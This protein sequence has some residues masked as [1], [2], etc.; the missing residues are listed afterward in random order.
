[1]ICAMARTEAE[2][3]GFRLQVRIDFVDT[4]GTGINSIEV[5]NA[6]FDPLP[7]IEQ[8]PR[9]S[10]LLEWSVVIIIDRDERPL[11]IR[12][13]NCGDDVPPTDFPDN[14]P[15]V[16]PDNLPCMERP[17]GP[18]PTRGCEVID[19]ECISASYE[20]EELLVEFRRKCERCDFLWQQ[21][22][23][24]VGMRIASL[25]IGAA[26]ALM[27]LLFLQ[28]GFFGAILA[29]LA[30]AMAVYFFVRARLYRDE[31][32]RFD[33]LAR[34]CDDEL[35]VI[36]GRYRLLGNTLVDCCEDCVGQPPPAPC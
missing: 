9:G 32:N 14:G 6:A 25:A 29:A 13:T 22:R 12:A 20:M 28:A 18:G 11:W 4:S 3:S 35:S 16:P 2:L 36:R 23:T 33:R 31:A 7:S 24:A 5:V 21:K 26:A 34:E 15:L 1:M 30:A 17:G 10:C 27:A 19:G 8:P